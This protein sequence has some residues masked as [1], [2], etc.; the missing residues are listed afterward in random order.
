MGLPSIVTD[1]NGSREIIIEGKNGIII[2]PR[3][4][5]ALYKAMKKIIEQSNMRTKM[6]SNARQLISLRYEQSYVRNCLKE[7]YNEILASGRY[8]TIS[9][10]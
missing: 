5:N 10:K 1:I 7:Y 9:S 2:P 4:T 3:D 8:A 6:A